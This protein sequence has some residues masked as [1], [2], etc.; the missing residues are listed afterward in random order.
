[1][2][3]VIVKLT[4]TNT[5]FTNDSIE[6]YEASRVEDSGNRTAAASSWTKSM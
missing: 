4:L 1:M 5:N 6:V 3:V 2:K